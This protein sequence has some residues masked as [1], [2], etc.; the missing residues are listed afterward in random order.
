MGEHNA[1]DLSLPAAGSQIHIIGIGGIGTSGQARVLARWGYRVTGSDTAESSVTTAL[2]AEGLDVRIGHHPELVTDAALVVYS[3]AV[4]EDDPELAAAR[5]AGTATV[6]RAAL[7]GL[8]ANGRSGL[9]VAGTHGKSSTSA[10]LAKICVN[11]GCDPSFF[12]G[13]IL[14]D[15]GTNARPGGGELVVVEADEYDRSF[16]QLAPQVAIVTTVEA[17]HP[18]TYPTY[19]EMEQAYLDFLG[20]VRPGGTI[21]VSADDAGVAALLPRLTLASGVT[22][23]R[24]G[25][26]VDA[27]WRIV[28][29]GDTDRVLYR[30]ESVAILT[31]PVPGEH[32]RRNAL[33]AL[34]AAA[35]VGIAPTVAAASLAGFGGTGRRFEFKGEVRGITVI[36]DYGHHPTEVAVNVRAA[37]DR[38]PGRELWVIFQP[39]TYSRTKLLLREFAEALALVD[40]LVLLDIYASRESDTL[41]MSSDDLL[42]LLPTLE[43]VLRPARPDDAVAALLAEHR[44]GRLATGAVV[45]TFGAGDVTEVG[46]LVLEGLAKLDERD[47]ARSAATGGGAGRRLARRGVASAGRCRSPGGVAGLARRAGGPVHQFS[48]RWPRRL[49]RSS[50]R[51]DLVARRA[52]L[53]A[54]GGVTGDDHRWRQQPDLRRSRRARRGDQLPRRGCAAG[55]VGRG[56]HSA[57]AR[58]GAADGFPASRVT[59]ATRAGPGWIGRSACR[60]RS[61]GR[62]RTTPGRT[63][64]R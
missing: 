5:A 13:A 26:A 38:F 56:R 52:D 63:A 19:G 8:I 53:G 64:P 27:D 3:A 7:L 42:P 15:F 29:E 37:R 60:A 47:G 31:M 18:D 44:A 21:L 61:A 16:L 30:G 57:G 58:P 23:L 25:R 2:R 17:D 4:R 40:R 20:Q 14:R 50:G 6:K 12:V 62:W 33:A 55:C 9:A 45:M 34:G 36:D 22:L 24:Y 28:A 46:T 51:R 59:A 41:G 54:R 39:H 49:P 48:D 35:A 10:M 1:P 43:T 11:A 32:M